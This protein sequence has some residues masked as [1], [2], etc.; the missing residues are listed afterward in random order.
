MLKLGI[1]G[2]PLGHTL[3][4]LLHCTLMNHLGLH[5]EY[6]AYDIPS[7]ELKVRLAELRNAGLR[8]LNV[9]IPH[10]VAILELLDG[11]S[12]EAL[13]IG[14]VNT[15]VMEES[16]LFGYNTDVAGFLAGL[17]RPV[18]GERALVLGG[19][20]AAR[21]VIAGLLRQQVS[22]IMLAVRNPDKAHLVRVCGM[23]TG[24]ETAVTVMALEDLPSLA[25]C[26]LVVNTTPVGMSP[27]TDESPLNAAQ[28]K[29]LPLHAL[30]YDLI[31]RPRQ[32]RLLAMAEAQGLSTQDGLEMLVHQ[33][34]E[35]FYLWTGLE[36]VR[37]PELPALLREALAEDLSAP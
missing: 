8:G 21:A 13:L 2:H 22:S 24:I 20:G 9:T 36:S 26:G 23:L 25:E 33:G 30:V 14:A 16:G 28:I 1:I 7:A 31:Y 35:A 4:P 10:K 34:L 5:G 11:L 3:S 12:D 17:P 6:R 32:T 15:V 29:T 37:Q 18:T 19:G 27:H